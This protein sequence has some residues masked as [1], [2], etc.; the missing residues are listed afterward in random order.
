MKSLVETTGEFQLLLGD[1]RLIRSQGY[2]VVE[3]SE[4]VHART[5]L[6]QVRTVGEVNDDATDEEWLK[7]VSESDGDLEL[8]LASFVSSFPTTG[9]KGAAPRKAAAEPVQNPIVIGEEE[10]VVERVEPQRKGNNR[11]S[12]LLG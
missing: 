4:F 12:K 10:R 5:V 8:A 9:S 7:F 1:G 11:H 2:T 3:R 6:G